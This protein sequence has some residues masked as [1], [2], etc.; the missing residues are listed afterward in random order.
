MIEIY[1]RNKE[2]LATI[3][4]SKIPH[5]FASKHPKSGREHLDIGTQSYRQVNCAH[6]ISICI[7]SGVDKKGHLKTGVMVKSEVTTGKIFVSFF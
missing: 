3:N 5:I 6:G 1:K 7:F 4:F 2:T